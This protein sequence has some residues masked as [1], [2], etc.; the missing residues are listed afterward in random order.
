ML[1]VKA[2]ILHLQSIILS[3]TCCGKNADAA[4]NGHIFQLLSLFQHSVTLSRVEH[5]ARQ[6]V[7][8]KAG[9]CYVRVCNFSILACVVLV[10]VLLYKIL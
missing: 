6:A 7:T 1:T 10:L 4:E 2:S 9:V 8:I 5:A 3:E